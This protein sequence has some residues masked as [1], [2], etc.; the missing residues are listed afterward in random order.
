M[1]DPTSNRDNPPT[2]SKRSPIR[3]AAPQSAPQS[4]P[5][6]PSNTPA[7]P[8]AEGDALTTS[9]TSALNMLRAKMEFV[10]DEFAQGNI[11][12]AQFNAVYKRY[13][14]Q[15]AIIER[16][17]ERN[18]D[19]DAWKQVVSLKGQ[20]GFLRHH[21]EAQPLYFAAYHKSSPKPIMSEG[22]SPPPEG[23]ITSLLKGVWLMKNRPKHALGR[24]PIGESHWL[25]LAVG[26]FAATAVL[27][28]LEP[29]NAQ[30]RLVRDLHADFERAN[31]AALERG[32]IVP[33]R[34]VFPQ[35]AITETGF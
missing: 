10:A 1:D 24:K 29:S 22:K 14:E 5:P 28:S 15:R 9:P 3:P 23:V 11:N 17:I 25:L 12:R 2:E 31:Q 4:V 27:F 13:S 7:P 34:M 6:E 8:F 35:R 33:E 32:W 26:D 30:A 18:P 21:F 20:T 19:S 16:L